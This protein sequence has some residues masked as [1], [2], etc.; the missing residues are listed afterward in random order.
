LSHPLEIALGLYGLAIFKPQACHGHSLGE[1]L[2]LLSA[3]FPNNMPH[4]GIIMVTPE[5]IPG[6]Q[7]TKKEKPEPPPW[8]YTV[9]PPKVERCSYF[10]QHLA[11]QPYTYSKRVLGLLLNLHSYPMINSVAIILG[12]EIWG[13]LKFQT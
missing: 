10:V 9:T 3:S 5:F 8:L 2:G 13:L 4:W 6:L 12:I 7:N 1:G 11:E